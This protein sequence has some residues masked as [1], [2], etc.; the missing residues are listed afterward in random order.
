M[1]FWLPPEKGSGQL[2]YEDSQFQSVIA[3]RLLRFGERSFV[4][5]FRTLEWMNEDFTRQPEGLL[6]W[7]QYGN[8][9]P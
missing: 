9:K 3:R 2:N 5:H 6:R 7:G 1:P 8:R 4:F